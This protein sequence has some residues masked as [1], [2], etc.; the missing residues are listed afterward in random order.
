MGAVVYKRVQAC[1]AHRVALIFPKIGMFWLHAHRSTFAA[2][3]AVHMHCHSHTFFEKCP[4]CRQHMRTA[5]A[6]PRCLLYE[7][8]ATSGCL[9]HGRRHVNKHR[10]AYQTQQRY[11]TLWP[12]GIYAGGGVICSMLPEMANDLRITPTLR[13][14]PAAVVSRSVCIRNTRPVSKAVQQ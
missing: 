8:C 5:N 13:M 12:C 4:C 1:I 6:H 14:Y 10:P 7:I 9:L 2:T 11:N 3:I